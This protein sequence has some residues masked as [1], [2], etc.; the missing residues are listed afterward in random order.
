MKSIAF[1]AVMNYI[2]IDYDDLAKY[3]YKILRRSKE[4]VQN[5]KSTNA[6]G[7]HLSDEC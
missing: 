5:F 7:E 6:C 3:F 4:Y 2:N 1:L